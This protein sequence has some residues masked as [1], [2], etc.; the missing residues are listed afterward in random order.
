MT[1]VIVKIYKD[2]VKLPGTGVEDPAQEISSNLAVSNPSVSKF[3]LGSEIQWRKCT[4][5][6]EN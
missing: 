2:G 1:K 5:E 4:R 3:T 6:A